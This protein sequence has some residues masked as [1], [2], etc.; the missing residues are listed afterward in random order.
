VQTEQDMQ[1]T[2]H[3]AKGLIVK[4]R[5]NWS[6]WCAACGRS[7]WCGF[8]VLLRHLAPTRCTNPSQPPLA[9]GGL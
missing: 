5:T 7:K 3:Y 1:D 4:G 6:G 9:R 8:V 2:F